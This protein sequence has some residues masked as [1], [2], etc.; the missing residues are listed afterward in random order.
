MNA[1]EY[2]SL[3]DWPLSWAFQEDDEWTM[4]ERDLAELRPI[5]VGSSRELWAMYVADEHH[6]MLVSKGTRRF[7]DECIAKTRVGEVGPDESD[8]VRAFLREHVPAL[9]TSPVYYLWGAATGCETTWRFLLEYWDDFDY[10]SDDS[11]VAL[12]P[13]AGRVIVHV[14]G[15]IW[16]HAIEI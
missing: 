3:D 5:A 13:D 8:R 15:G 1:V 11:N 9:P 7:A 16:I 12:V 4:P 10:P 6:L 2:I 14:E